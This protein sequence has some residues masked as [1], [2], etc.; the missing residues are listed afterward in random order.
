MKRNLKMQCWSD[1]HKSVI[2]KYGLPQLIVYVVGIPICVFIFLKTNFDRLT[3]IE[4]IRKA[5][6]FYTGFKSKYFYWQ[7]I[8]IYFK[9]IIVAVLIIALLDYDKYLFVLGTFTLMQLYLN[10]LLFFKPYVSESLN[11]MDVWS[12]FASSL[13]VLLASCFIKEDLDIFEH[14]GFKTGTFVLIIVINVCFLLYFVIKIY[15]IYKEKAK[16][17]AE[18]AASIIKKRKSRKYI[19]H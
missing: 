7:I 8:V 1:H 5:G 14:T 4:V 13:T 10:S 19:E 2:L 11:Q 6:I 3:E 12:T 17:T 15:P 18:K 16:K 9:K